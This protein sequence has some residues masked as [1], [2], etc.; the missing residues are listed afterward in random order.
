MQIPQQEGPLC[1]EQEGEGALRNKVE[2]RVLAFEGEEHTLDR[3][4]AIAAGLHGGEVKL[5]G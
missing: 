1:H 4:E 2:L 3:V 5:S